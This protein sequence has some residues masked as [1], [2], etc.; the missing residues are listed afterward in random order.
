M[1]N[2]KQKTMQALTKLRQSLYEM[3]TLC[4]MTDIVNITDLDKN[5]QNITD[6]VIEASCFAY[7]S[8]INESVK[9]HIWYL[10][11]V[12]LERDI[13]EYAGQCFDD[14]DRNLVTKYE[15][16]VQVLYDL[17]LQVSLCLEMLQTT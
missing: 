12:I 5:L 15:I 14:N 11:D 7:Q 13:F 1:T 4:D 16:K 9:Q 6:A 10:E 3:A 2:E 17:A 8:D